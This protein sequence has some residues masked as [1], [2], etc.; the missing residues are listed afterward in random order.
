MIPSA[1]EVYLSTCTESC[2]PDGDTFLFEKLDTLFRRDYTY[3]DDQLD[4]RGSERIGQKPWWKV[5]L[6]AM[7]EKRQGFN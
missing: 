5:M 4:E 2:E 6:D 7:K 1:V 3:C